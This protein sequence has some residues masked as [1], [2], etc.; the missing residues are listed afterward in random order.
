MS[1]CDLMNVRT[2]ILAAGKKSKVTNGGHGA[3]YETQYK[4]ISCLRA[5]HYFAYAKNAIF[6]FLRLQTLLIKCS[7]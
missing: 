2:E 5:M 7:H 4:R 3:G 6:L 1:V